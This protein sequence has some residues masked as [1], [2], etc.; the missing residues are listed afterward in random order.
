MRK[1]YGICKQCGDKIVDFKYA[2]TDWFCERCYF[3]KFPLRPCRDEEENLPNLFDSHIPGEESYAFLKEQLYD[4]PGLYENGFREVKPFINS[5]QSFATLTQMRD[6]CASQSR[7][8]RNKL[9]SDLI[10]FAR[11]QKVK[12]LF[13]RVIEVLMFAV[14][15]DLVDDYGTGER[16]SDSYWD[17]INEI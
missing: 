16:F 5:L 12:P 7:D 11:T 13:P 1:N 14:W 4:K 3:E 15:T 17:L 9:K 6:F 2:L 10:A 8:Y